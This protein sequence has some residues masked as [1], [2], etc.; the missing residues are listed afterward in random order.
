MEKNGKV[1]LVGAGPGDYNLMTLKGLECIRK[2]DVIIYDRLASEEF[3][4]EKKKGCELI[5]VGKKSSSHILSQD[6]INKLIKKKAEEGKIVTRL[7][8]G[9]PYVF[10]R[11]GEEAEE[12]FESNIDFEVVPGVSSAIAGLCYAGIPITHRD[13]ASSFHVITGHP[14]SEDIDDLDWENISRIEGTLVFLMGLKNIKHI[15]DSLISFGKDEKT[16]VALISWATR[17][18]Q[19]TVITTLGDMF[20]DS[21]ENKMTSPLLIVVGGVVSLSE[22]LN[23]F[24]SKPLFSKRIGITRSKAQNSD[25]AKRITDLGAKIDE[26]PTIKIEE[27]DDDKDIIQAIKNIGR[28]SYIVFNSKNGVEVFFDKVNKCEKDSRILSGVKVCSI[29][30]VTSEALKD[31]G[32]TPDIEPKDYVSES[33]FEELKK[34]VDIGDR[35]LV[36]KSDISRNFLE[37]NLSNYCYVEGLILYHT[38]INREDSEKILDLLK[39]NKLDY[40]TFT[41][42]STVKNLVEIIGQENLGI[43]SETRCISIGSITSKTMK[44]EGIEVFSQAEKSSIDSMIYEIVKNENSNI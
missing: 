32:I 26:I 10:G 33:L 3:L 23:F 27:I 16:P 34:V 15:G 40:L 13:F 44:E 12:L 7:K 38:R 1:F 9:D 19:K 4:K 29:G 35:V 11:G 36:L 31:R 41:S 6:K 8:G 18:N 24:E 17:Y 22:K 37:K 2:S 20:R 30:N 14:K 39:N 43:L 5:Y 21:V 42:S 25:L 28:Y